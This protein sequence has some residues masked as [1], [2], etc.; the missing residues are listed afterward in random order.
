MAGAISAERQKVSI[1]AELY[2][3]IPDHHGENDVRFNI[4]SVIDFNS[5]NH[6]LFSAG[7]SFNNDTQF[8]CYI[9][10][11]YTISKEDKTFSKK[12]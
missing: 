5:Q 11:Q 3:I 8:Q 2:D 6:L 4:G 1:G 10:Y 12:F 7:R 9:G